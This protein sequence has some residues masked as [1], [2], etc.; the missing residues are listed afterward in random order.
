MLSALPAGPVGES[1]GSK[2]CIVAA[3]DVSIVSLATHFLRI[4]L[5]QER[6]S[7][8][9]RTSEG[10]KDRGRRKQEVNRILR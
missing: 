2:R 3:F 4:V 5:I 8:C 6:D 9:K 10:R 7:E 1:R